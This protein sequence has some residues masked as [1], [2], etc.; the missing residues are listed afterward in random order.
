[1]KTIEPPKQVFMAK[2]K[3]HE[4]AITDSTSRVL[5]KLCFRK[6]FY[7]IVLGFRPR[8]KSKPPYFAW[9]SAIH[10][11]WEVLY[12]DDSE[13]KATDAATTSWLLSKCA[14]P[15]GD[16]WD[17]MN[18]GRMALVFKSAL[19]FYRK[20]K[21]QGVI[22]VLE[23]ELPFEVE[24]T[25]PD[26]GDAIVSIGGRF[27][28]LISRNGRVAVRDWKNSKKDMAYYERQLDPNDQFTGYLIAGDALSAS[29]C[30]TCLVHLNTNTKKEGPELN[31]LITERTTAQKRQ[32]IKEVKTLTKLLDICRE[33][34]TWPMCEGVSYGNTIC[35]SCD[36]RAVCAAPSEI[37][38]MAKLEQLF[39]QKPWDFTTIGEE[40]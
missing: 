16:K 32:W 1:M 37:S 24:I 7:Q 36:F 39:E 5:M 30:K 10:K 6:Y 35:S 27:D 31:Q 11:F 22:K 18:I 4:P 17:F 34:D 25:D 20:E 40:G 9:G 13:Q 15:A 12:R 28:Q 14:P 3:R 33:E 29:E 21:A 2:F 23:I 19:E 26:N 8:E 38:Q